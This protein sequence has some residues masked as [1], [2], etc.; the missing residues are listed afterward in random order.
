MAAINW[1]QLTDLHQG[2]PGQRWLWPAIKD[3]FFD[4]LGKLH[5]KSGPWDLVLFTGDLTHTGS[6]DEFKRLS[7]TLGKLWGRIRALGS[8]P[9]LVTVPG[10][11]DL[12]RPKMN[13]AVR[14]LRQW[15]SEPDIRKEFW[16]THDN[17]YRLLVREAFAPYEAFR[18]EHSPPASFKTK[19]GLLPGD[20][21]ISF[22]K[23]G[24]SVAIV[25]LNSA[26]LQLTGDD[27][28]GRLD[29]DPRQFHAVTDLDEP[30]GWVKEHDFAFLLTHHPSTWLHPEAQETFREAV[31]PAG[32]FFAHQFGHMHEGTSTTTSIGGSTPVRAVQ[33]PSLFGLETWGDGSRQRLHGYMA[34]RVE[35]TSAGG[36]FKLWPRLAKK[37]KA[38]SWQMAPDYEFA[39]G[40][41]EATIEGFAHRSPPNR[42]GASG[43]R[44][45]AQTSVLDA[46]ARFHMTSEIQARASLADAPIG[47]LQARL[48]RMFPSQFEEVLSWLAISL[49]QPAALRASQA[50]RARAVVESL[51]AKGRISELAPVVNRV[52]KRER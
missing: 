10:N 9:A 8:C 39:L 43:Y 22:T 31:A 41:D 25:G 16:A 1:L 45:S 18:A 12:V 37:T 21:S 13:G 49:D 42:A 26:F 36:T 15:P 52:L 17:E 29:L 47:E 38:G 4:D 5:E 19:V 3:A 32:L 48:E 46:G 30:F 50:E 6:A 34:A 24:L 28:L 35:V 40:A 27:Y 14:A 7:D 33:G 2:M 20:G 44:S 23:D 51:M 11:H